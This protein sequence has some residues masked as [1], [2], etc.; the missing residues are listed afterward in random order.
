MESKVQ[1]PLPP[2]NHRPPDYMKNDEAVDDDENTLQAFLKHSYTISL[3]EK[4]L[5][6]DLQELTEQ[7]MHLIAGADTVYAWAHTQI[8]TDAFHSS[9]LMH[10]LREIFEMPAVL[11]DP[12]ESECLNFAFMKHFMKACRDEWDNICHRDEV[13]F[14][15]SAVENVWYWFRQWYLYHHLGAVLVE[16]K[17]LV[18]M[19]YKF[20]KGA[21]ETSTKKANYA[22]IKCNELQEVEAAVKALHRYE[23]KVRAEK[24]RQEEAKKKKEQAA[25]IKRQKQ[26]HADKIKADA[27]KWDGFEVYKFIDRNDD[28]DIK[29]EGYDD[30]YKAERWGTKAG[31]LY[32]NN[33]ADAENKLKDKRRNQARDKA[34]DDGKGRDKRR[35]QAGDNQKGRD[36]TGHAG[37]DEKKLECL[38]DTAGLDTD[39]YEYSEESDTDDDDGAKGAVKDD[40]AVRTVKDDGPKRGAIN[41]DDGTQGADDTYEY[42]DSDDDDGAKGAVKDDDDGVR[43][44]K[45]YDGRGNADDDG[46]KSKRAVKNDDTKTADDIYEF[47]NDDDDGGKSKR[48]VKN[49]DDTKSADDI[50][51]DSGAETAINDA[52]RG[53]DD[54]SD[55]RGR[56][57][58]ERAINEHE[59]ARDDQSDMTLCHSMTSSFAMVY[60]C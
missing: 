7:Y 24:E 44:V 58:D 20:K 56:S 31:G 5:A 43:N 30:E 2:V 42:S 48:A 46:A 19:S 11:N 36:Q 22:A 23:L 29:D 3:I 15:R 38:P 8:N 53:N 34:K 39:E 10:S 45:D 26:R 6:G 27:R 49:V 28:D 41:D 59:Q 51:I 21:A 47:I 13:W 60:K 14:M 12:P 40:D 25:A 37:T 9:V 4:V 55:G 50:Y 32:E 1:A 35:A 17:K 54:G 33:E 16:R 18:M 52:K 57:E